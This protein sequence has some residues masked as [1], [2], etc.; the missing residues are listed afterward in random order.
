MSVFSVRLAAAEA[1]DAPALDLDGRILDFRELARRVE[2]E[3]RRLAP[4]LAGHEGAWITPRP[5]RSSLIRLLALIELGLPARLLHPRLPPAERDALIARLP[6]FV[7]LDA[8][9]QRDLPLPHPAALPAP[10]PDDGRPLVI[11]STSGSSGPPRGVV[12]SRMGLRRA[13]EASARRL[14]WRRNDRWLLALPLAH[15]GGLSVLLRCLAAR[16]CVVVPPDTTPATLGRLLAGGRV[17]LASL[18]PTQLRRILDAEPALEARAPLRAILLGGAPADPAL[19]ARAAA[20]RLPVLVTYGLSEAGSQVT[21]QLP[22]TPPDPAQG[23]GPP[24]PGYQVRIS[25]EGRIQVRSPSLLSAYRPPD[26]T[27]PLPDA[28]GWLTT[29]DLGWIDEEGRLHPTG[30]ADALI[31]TGGENVSPEQVEG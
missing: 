10:P 20:R 12:L 28:E 29:S 3:A 9:A 16:R 21:T 6:R 7:D 5:T 19:L 27:A 18:V 4:R 1:P 22:G 23:A 24:L 15:V 14:G 2:G 11:V 25:P 30:R 31:L 13:V 26:P 8:P 17:S